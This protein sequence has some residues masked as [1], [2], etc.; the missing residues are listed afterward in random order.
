MFQQPAAFWV[1]VLTADQP[2]PIWLTNPAKSNS[3]FPRVNCQLSIVNCWSFW[4]S[5]IS[6]KFPAALTKPKQG[7]LPF[8]LKTSL[9]L[10]NPQDLC[11]QLGMDYAMSRKDIANDI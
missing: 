11:L 7:R 1:F 9:S 10:Q 3:F 2:L 8:S 4:I 6:S 5:A